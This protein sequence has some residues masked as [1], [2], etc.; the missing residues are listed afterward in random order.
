MR[1]RGL[2]V[3]LIAVAVALF[4]IASASAER[5]PGSMHGGKP[6]ETALLPGNEVP[7]HATAATGLT[8]ITVNPGQSEVCWEIT[9]SGL[10]APATAAHIH[11]GPPGVAGAIVIPTPVPNVTSGTGTGCAVVASPLAHDLAANPTGY[12]V[13]VHDSVFPGGEIRG[14]L[15]DV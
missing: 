11:F 2:V 8:L 15:H 14:Q 7:P 3:F 1:R 10:S 6:L 13:N 9:F 4:G 12:Y 5:L